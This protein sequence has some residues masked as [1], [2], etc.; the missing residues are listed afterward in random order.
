MLRTYKAHSRG[1]AGEAQGRAYGTH[2]KSVAEFSE[3]WGAEILSRRIPRSA[4]PH[5]HHVYYIQ[6]AHFS[7]PR[8]HLMILV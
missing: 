5:A 1:G 6:L 2:I 3:S 7:D 4:P 8:L